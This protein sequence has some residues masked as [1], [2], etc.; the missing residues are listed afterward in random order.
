MAASERKV[1][2]V[3]PECSQ[4][5][6]ISALN[7]TH[8]Y[9]SVF[10]DTEEYDKI[11]STAEDQVAKLEEGIKDVANPVQEAVPT[12]PIPGVVTPNVVKYQ[13]GPGRL[14]V[15]RNRLKASAM[16]SFPTPPTRF[17]PA[18]R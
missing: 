11:V 3:L 5:S 10:E 14:Q 17:D 4:R 12:P 15:R 7:E 6:L 2:K 9:V 16:M 1:T 18:R 8:F 13:D